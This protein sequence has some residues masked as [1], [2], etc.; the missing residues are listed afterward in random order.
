[1]TAHVCMAGWSDRKPQN[2]GKQPI[3]SSLDFL[4]LL[5]TS[6]VDQQ[7]TY[8]PFW[9]GQ[10]NTDGD[11]WLCAFTE[12]QKQKLILY[13]NVPC[14]PRKCMA[15]LAERK[16]FCFLQGADKPQK[17][18]DKQTVFSTDNEAAALKKV[19]HKEIHMGHGR[20][21]VTQAITMDSFTILPDSCSDPQLPR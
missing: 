2:Q 16:L 15:F 9:T 8:F 10:G 3:S 18:R 1:M 5:Q 11:I 13:R 12:I 19:I 17:T 21:C 4:Q 6:T 7:L 14:K 20:W